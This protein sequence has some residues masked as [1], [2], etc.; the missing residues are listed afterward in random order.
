MN[1]QLFG[2]NLKCQK[3]AMKKFIIFF[4]FLLISL[5]STY[6]KDTGIYKVKELYSDCLNEVAFLDGTLSESTAST[7]MIIEA[8]SC[9]YYIRGVVDGLL[10]ANMIVRATLDDKVPQN[11]IPLCFP[12]DTLNSNDLVKIYVAYVGKHPEIMKDDAYMSI[13][14]AIDSTFK[15]GLFNE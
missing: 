6:A 8:I 11:I 1:E 12:Q 10:I 9:K 7:D 4:F 5:N 3:D 13:P 15:C 14:K 2:F